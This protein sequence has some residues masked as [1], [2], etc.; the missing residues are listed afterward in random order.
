VLPELERVASRALGMKSL[1]ATASRSCTASGRGGALRYAMSLPVATTIQRIDSLAVLRQNLTI[2]ARSS[3]DERSKKCRRSAAL[4][5]LCGTGTW[6]SNKSTKKYARRRWAASSTAIRRRNQL[7]F[8][9]YDTSRKQ[10]SLLD[11]TT[12]SKQR[13]KFGR[14]GKTNLK[15]GF[16]LACRAST[17]GSKS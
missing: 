11:C 6:S 10:I 8:R 5:V 15:S 17:R 3:A 4:R 16:P 1:A 7:R 12:S 13:A 14:K 2:G 9:D